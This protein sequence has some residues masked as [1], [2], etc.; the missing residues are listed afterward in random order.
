MTSEGVA[1]LLSHDTLGTVPI[2]PHAGSWTLSLEIAQC[3]FHPC[4]P[5]HGDFCLD[6]SFLKLI[7][8]ER[9]G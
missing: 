2:S 5:S 4:H 6:V 7:L 8:R 1:A 3:A 9:E